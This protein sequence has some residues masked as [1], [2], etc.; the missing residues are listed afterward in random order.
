VHFYLYYFCN[1]QMTLDI[2][3]WIFLPWTR[4]ASNVR[5]PPPPLTSTFDDVIVD[6][7]DPDYLPLPEYPVR[8]N[9]PLDIRKQR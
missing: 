9:E 6:Y 7:E 8:P 2:S 1:D 4:C 5:N 3:S